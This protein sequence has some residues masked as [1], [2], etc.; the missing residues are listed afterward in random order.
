VVRAGSLAL[1]GDAPA[2]SRFSQRVR[3]RG[4]G[5]TEERD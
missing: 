5:R 3:E 2:R 1:G 4:V